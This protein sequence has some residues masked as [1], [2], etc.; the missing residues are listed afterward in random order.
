MTVLFAHITRVL[1]VAGSTRNI[2]TF[3]EVQV[4][5]EVQ[6]YAVTVARSKPRCWLLLLD[7]RS[8][9]K[10]VLTMLQSVTGDPN[11]WATSH[12][13]VRL[14][15]LLGQRSRPVVGTANFWPH[16]DSDAESVAYFTETDRP[17]RKTMKFILKKGRFNSLELPAYQISALEVQ[18]ATKSIRARNA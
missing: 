6:R 17:R 3:G 11:S 2:A 1:P 10:A 16:F 8:S 12:S 15:C 9:A 7:N 14:G 4:E 5:P 13:V 18:T